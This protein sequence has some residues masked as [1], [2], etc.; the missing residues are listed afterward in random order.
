MQSV[1]FDFTPNH[2]ITVGMKHPVHVNCEKAQDET[3]GVQCDSSSLWRMLLCVTA[4]GCVVM[5]KCLV[6]LEERA[7]STVSEWS[8]YL[9]T[10]SYS[11]QA[12]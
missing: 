8:R 4:A 1:L 5:L 2:K 7:S 6:G 11:I 3:A 12:V 9:K 10:G